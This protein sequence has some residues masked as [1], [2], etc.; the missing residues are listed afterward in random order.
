M[1][2]MVMNILLS[3]NLVPKLLFVVVQFQVGR[4]INEGSA[5]KVHVARNSLLALLCRTTKV[6]PRPFMLFPWAAS[7]EMIRSI[8]GS[9]P[10]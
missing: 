1:V 8:K 9:R 6:S 4:Y 2:V 3:K 10:P 5:S 7:L